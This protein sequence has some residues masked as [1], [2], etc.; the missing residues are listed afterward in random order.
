MLLSAVIIG[1]ILARSARLLD[2]YLPASYNSKRARK[3]TTDTA[4]AESNV[5]SLYN[6]G[7]V[8]SDGVEEDEVSMS[9]ESM[10]GR[11]EVLSVDLR[12]TR[13][14]KMVT[15]TSFCVLLA[16]LVVLLVPLF[17]T[18]VASPNK[19]HIEPF[20]TGCKLYYTD[21]IDDLYSS[22]T[23]SSD[24]QADHEGGHRG[25]HLGDGASGRPLRRWLEGR[26]IEGGGDYQCAEF[27]VPHILAPTFRGITRRRGIPVYSGMCQEHGYTTK[28]LDKTLSALWYSLDVELYA[29]ND[30][31]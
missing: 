29:S 18:L 21:A 24:D 3:G 13:R 14:K 8:K 19:V 10:D 20:Y 25:L 12:R 4:N 5:S 17:I 23:S 7:T 11:R 30:G 2:R 15:R 22:F 16:V 28:V 6:V 27:C 9:Y 31:N 1:P 26:R